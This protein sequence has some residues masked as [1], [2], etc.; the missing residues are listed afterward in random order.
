[1]ICKNV[2]F[3]STDWIAMG[4]QAPAADARM[5]KR[6]CMCTHVPIEELK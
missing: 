3:H 6:Q 4:C 2:P 1:M 5:A